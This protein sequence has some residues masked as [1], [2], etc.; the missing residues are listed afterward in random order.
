MRK[1]WTTSP[2]PP[3]RFG[4]EVSRFVE[5]GR[6]LTYAR[7]PLRSITTPPDAPG[8]GI[9]WTTLALFT[10]TMR[11]SLKPDPAETVQ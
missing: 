9:V 5:F 10:L 4:W 2:W 7:L 8:S 11:M 1:T 3:G 6:P